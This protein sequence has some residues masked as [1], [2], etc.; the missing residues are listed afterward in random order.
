MSAHEIS[1]FPLH[2][3]LFPEMP[4]PLHIFEPRYRE[5]IGLCLADDRRFGVVL[6]RSGAEV[7]APAVPFEVGTVAEIA[8]VQQHEDGRLNLLTIGRERFR[9]LQLTQRAPYLRGV[10]ELIDDPAAAEP[11]Q[12]RDAARLFRQYLEHFRTMTGQE[13][14]DLELPEQPDRLSYLIGAALQIPAAELQ[15]L[16]ELPGARARLNEEA[17]ILRRELV[18]LR[19]LGASGNRFP[20]TRFSP[21]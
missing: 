2:T 8:E 19:G 21:N 7:G 3:V 15:A 14:F 4:L 12:V 13:P 9:I 1:L 5:M 17:V 20:E 18:F 6:I 16:L 10:V 11:E